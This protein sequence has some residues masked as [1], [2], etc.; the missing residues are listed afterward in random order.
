MI[1]Y[2]IIYLSNTSFQECFKFGDPKVKIIQIGHELFLAEAHV[3]ISLGVNFNTLHNHL[4]QEYEFSRKE[5]DMNISYD[6]SKLFTI[7]PGD[8]R[9]IIGWLSCWKS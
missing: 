5:I 1:L 7:I 3:G 2:L 8:Y 4:P 9:I 6:G